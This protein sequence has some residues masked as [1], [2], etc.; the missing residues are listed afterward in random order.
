MLIRGC[1]LLALA[2]VASTVL[3]HHSFVADYDNAKPGTVTGVISNYLDINPHPR[4]W[5]DVTQP[6]GTLV[7][8][9]A[10]GQRA[11]AEIAIGDLIEVSGYLH[12]RQEN[13]IYVTE[14][15]LSDGVTLENPTLD[16]GDIRSSDAP[17]E[18]YVSYA[19]EFAAYGNTEHPVDITGDWSQRYRGM[20]SI[21]DLSPQPIPFTAAGREA[22]QKNQ[23][24]GSDPGLRCMNTGLARLLSGPSVMKIYEVGPLYIFH[25]SQ[26]QQAFRLIYMDGRQAPENHALSNF[27]FSTGH[28]DGDTLVI[29]TTHL[30]PM[31][32]DVTG[33]MSSGEQTRLVETYR[34]IEQGLALERKMTFHDPFYSEPLTRTRYSGRAAHAP[35]ADSKGCDPDPFYFDLYNEDSLES[36]FEQQ[37]GET[38]D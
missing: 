38:S 7:T 34:I 1:L 8:W 10:Q 9:E 3:A 13:S 2:S 29:E 37:I 30:K 26:G 17:V 32:L 12:R 36:W 11:G 28:W 18:N 14:M 19:E 31:W 6:D 20:I 24:Y 21:N 35:L 16:P 22:F 33:L 15:Q 27:G 5:I 4:F 25:Y 23:A